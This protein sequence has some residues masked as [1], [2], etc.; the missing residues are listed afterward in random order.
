MPVTP[1]SQDIADYIVDTALPRINGSGNYNLTVSG[2]DIYDGL[3][4]VKQCSNFPSLCLVEENP[5]QYEVIAQED[6]TT[7]DNFNDVGQGDIIEIVGYVKTS[8]DGAKS[9]L[10]AQQQRQL[11]SDIILAM[12]DS[13]DLG[14]N[15]TYIQL[16]GSVMDSSFQQNHNIGTVIVA[17]SVK[18]DFRPTDATP[19]TP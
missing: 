15:A 6:Y 19:S 3:V 18:Y 11:R 1:Q 8:T 16:A 4:P 12:L 7:G 17:F 5:T 9:G 2:T 10:L 14:G 13:S